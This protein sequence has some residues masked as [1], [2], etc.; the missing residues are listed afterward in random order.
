MSFTIDRIDHVVL[1]CREV[2][3]MA[4]WYVRALGMQR[5]AFGPHGRLALKFGKL[6][7][8][9]SL[10]PAIRLARNGFPLYARLQGGLKYK[11]EA[12]LLAV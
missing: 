10:Q 11:R 2:D 5:E 6:S 12:M 9:E 3:A 4:A 8:K 7:L 1:N